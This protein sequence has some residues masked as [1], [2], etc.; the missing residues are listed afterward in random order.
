MRTGP[1]PNRREARAAADVHAL[2][3]EGGLGPSGVS[4]V[5]GTAYSTLWFR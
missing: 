2:V 4:G 5:S 1:S 3:A